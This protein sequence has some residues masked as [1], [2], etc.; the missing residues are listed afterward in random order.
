MRHPVAA[1][2][3]K[4]VHFEPFCLSY[5][6]RYLF[7]D[8][9]NNDGSQDIL[10]AQRADGVRDNA[11]DLYPRFFQILGDPQFTSS[12]LILDGCSSGQMMT[13]LDFNLDGIVDVAV[14][15]TKTVKTLSGEAVD[16]NICFLQGSESG[17]DVTN[18]I[19]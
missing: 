6:N 11:E 5:D 3:E 14:M 13:T 9:R 7:S 8:I 19:S 15:P 4:R 16:S 1:I 2:E 17:L 18:C 12:E 10:R